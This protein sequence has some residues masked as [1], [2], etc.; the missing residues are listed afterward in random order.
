MSFALIYNLP[1]EVFGR[2]HDSEPYV[3]ASAVEVLR[4]IWQLFFSKFTF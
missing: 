4:V 2:I 3:R 1:L